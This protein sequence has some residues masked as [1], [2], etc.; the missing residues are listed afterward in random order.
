MTFE[1]NEWYTIINGL[2]VAA[3]RFIENASICDRD[4]QPRIAAQFRQQAEESRK[5]AERIEN[6]L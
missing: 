5:I 4:N 2:R 6:N 3:E 1:E